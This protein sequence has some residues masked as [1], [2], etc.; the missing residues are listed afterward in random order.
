MIGPMSDL[1]VVTKGVNATQEDMQ[2]LAKGFGNAIAS[3]KNIRMLKQFGI[4]VDQKLFSQKTIA[5][6]YKFLLDYAKGFASESV[7]A[8]ATPE[9]R[10]QLL[11]NRIKSLSREIG[12]AM[13]PARADMADAWREVL[14]DLEPVF[15]GI[16]IAAAKAATWAGKEISDMTKAL[17]TPK[18]MKTWTDLGDSFKAIYSAISGVQAKP[19]KE[20]AGTM[21]GEWWQKQLQDF[22]DDLRAGAIGITN[23][24]MKFGEWWAD[25]SAGMTVYVL[26][27]L[28]SAYKATIRWIGLL[29]D[30]HIKTALS[31]IGRWIKESIDDP[32]GAGIKHLQEL[33][34]LLTPSAAA[35]AYGA[36]M[37]TGEENWAPALGGAGASAPAASAAG[38]VGPM[39]SGYAMGGAG[40]AGGPGLP[41]TVAS[42]GGPEE[43]GQVTGAYRNALKMGD[44]AISPNLY[45]I[46]GA[47]GPDNFVMLDGKRYH[48]ADSSFYSR[49][50]P[51]ANMVEIWGY[52]NQIKR[53]G[54]VSKAMQMGGIV[55]GMTHALLGERGPEAVIP[56]S[57][58]RRAEGLLNFASRALG[59][60]GGATHVSFAPNIVINGNATEAEQRAM[61]SRLRDLASDFIA[62][63]KRAQLQERRLS[64]EGGY[65]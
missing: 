3:G 61:D 62:Q 36:S 57:G 55:R 6:R 25:F 34:K 2:E 22:A 53:R 42:Y 52:G 59:M 13:M 49:G 37:G 40:A 28:E 47:P 33:K 45:P 10:V 43:P 63:F 56:L 19:T 17:S 15:K 1:L 16:G 9:G 20:T 60:G 18:A 64:Y 58:G 14:N 35:A 31:N 48:V 8:M 44:V 41:V 24:K 12:E 46:L 11:S 21:F 38:T 39:A 5:Q 23:L 29:D 30:T 54:V 32:I 27:F 51:T 50:N 26:P 7:R 65:A 4:F